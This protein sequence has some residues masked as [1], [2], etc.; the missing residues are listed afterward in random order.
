MPRR[1]QP[2]DVPVDVPSRSAWIDESIRQRRDGTGMYMLAAAV[3]DDVDVATVRS[4]VGTLA[5][6]RRRRAHW[7][8]A[9]D[10]DRRKLV[11]A[12]ASLPS[13]HLVVIG[14]GLDNSRQ[15]RGRRKCMQRL[16]WE[17]SEMGTSQAWIEARTPTLNVK[18]AAAV[19]AWRAQRI[20]PG[21][22]RVDFARP[23]GPQGEPLLWLPDI[24]AGAVG[25]ARGDG[26]PQFLTPLEPVL[27]EFTITLDCGPIKRRAEVPVMPRESS[28]PL[29]TGVRERVGSTSCFDCNTQTPGMHAQFLGGS[30]LRGFASIGHEGTTTLT[31]GW[32]MVLA[33]DRK[34]PAPDTVS[35]E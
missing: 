7:H 4:E 32:L 27:T 11:Q 10:A 12:V 20:I 21:A 13:V 14:M 2:P 34:D 18:D 23:Y 26:D 30:P 24:V 31:H 35:A 8:D 17:L 29:P 3:V 5:P 25:A 16:L 19:A 28:A 6:G 22:L 1:D 15:E 9:D 33:D